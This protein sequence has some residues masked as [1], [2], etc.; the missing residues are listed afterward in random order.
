MSRSSN[1]FRRAKN[2]NP[3]RAKKNEKSQED[4]NIRQR[5]NLRKRK[6]HQIVRGTKKR[7]KRSKD[8]WKRASFK[9]T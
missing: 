3:K 7:K 4:Q 6:G 9:K 1:L 8:F 2:Q 5:I